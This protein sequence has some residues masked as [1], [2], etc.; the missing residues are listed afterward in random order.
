MIGIGQSYSGELLSIP[1]GT[2]SKWRKRLGLRRLSNAQGQQQGWRRS[3]QH[4]RPCLTCHATLRLLPSESGQIIGW[5]DR[6]ARVTR[7]RKKLKLWIP[8]A[9]DRARIPVVK[10]GKANKPNWGSGYKRRRGF[11]VSKK[12][13]PERWLQWASHEELFAL[14]ELEQKTC[15]SKH[16]AFR[17]QMPLDKW[18]R[19]KTMT[20]QERLNEAQRRRYNE[21]QNY[22]MRCAV[23]Q[24]TSRIKHRLPL[25]WDSEQIL[26]ASIELVCAHIEALFGQGMTW[27]NHGQ[28]HI[29]HIMPLCKFDLTD[30]TQAK[31]A[32]NYKNLRPMWASVNIKKGGR[33]TAESQQVW[34]LLRREQGIFSN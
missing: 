26:G 13:S 20:S 19:V 32:G 11:C 17:S 31:L 14:K 30:P 4:F 21:D 25:D 24:A 5:N 15:W 7:V 22:K 10:A 33:W 28:W 2:V 34:E 29:D 9:F 23:R 8:N 18:R 3:I 6:G 12:S 16:P 1:S 27:L